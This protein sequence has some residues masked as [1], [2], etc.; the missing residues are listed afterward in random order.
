MSKSSLTN[1]IRLL[2]FLKRNTDKNHPATQ[3][4]IR[5]QMGDELSKQLMGDKGTYAR[6]LKEIADAFNTDSDGNLM[7]ES[8]FRINYPGYLQAADSGKKNGKVYYNHPFSEE[9]LTFLIECVRYTH[10]FTDEEKESLETRLK[11]EL[12]SKYYSD[13]TKG[14]IIKKLDEKINGDIQKNELIIKQ[15]REHIKRGHMTDITVLDVEGKNAQVYQVSPYRLVEKD[16]FFWLIC[17]WHE[18]PAETFSYP[19]GREHYRYDRFFPWYTD[20]LTAFRID[21]I[22]EVNTGRVPRK[23]K[24]HWT[25]NPISMGPPNGNK[26]YFIQESFTNNPRKIRNGSDIQKNLQKFDDMAYEVELKH[27]ADIKLN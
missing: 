8:D 13:E 2:E 5:E 21:L 18:R 25:M 27:G 7:D 17:N 11:H 16:G 20:K 19:G 23:T 3:Q 15:L 6:R 26:K 14:C 10:N 12:V 1:G 9:E 4:S 22:E 24:V